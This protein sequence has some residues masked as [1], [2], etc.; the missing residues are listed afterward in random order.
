MQNFKPHNSTLSPSQ[1]LSL[2]Q[3]T[4]TQR[5]SSFYMLQTRKVPAAL[6]QAFKDK[7]LIQSG[8]TAAKNDGRG[9]RLGTGS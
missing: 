4:S 9:A 7:I 8:M 3:A 5:T 1:K 2:Q 6:G